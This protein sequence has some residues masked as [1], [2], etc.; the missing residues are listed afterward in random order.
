MKRTSI[1]SRD[2]EHMIFLKEYFE[3]Y[4]THQNRYFFDSDSQEFIQLFDKIIDRNSSELKKGDE[5][6]RARVC[7]KKL[8]FDD[9]F[10]REDGGNEGRMNPKGMSFFYMAIDDITAMTEVKAINSDQITLFKLKLNKKFKI[11]DLSK[12]KGNARLMERDMDDEYYEIFKD[13]ISILL[14]KPMSNSDHKAV[15]IPTQILASRICY[16]DFDGISYTSSVGNGNN[17]VLFN[18]DKIDFEPMGDALL[19]RAEL[20][21]KYNFINMNS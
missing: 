18:F 17:V 7:D 16:K 6:Y 14:S 10:P 12:R 4:V 19:Y 8:E 15:Y 20:E 2:I 9:M 1:S 21:L 11:I 5:F 13:L 3:K